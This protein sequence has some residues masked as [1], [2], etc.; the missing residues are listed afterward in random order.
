MNLL[1]IDAGWSKTRASTGLAWWVDG[2][3]SARTS[4]DRWPQDLPAVAWDLVVL[5]APVLP[6]LPPEQVRE[7][8]KALSLG[9]FQKRCKPGFTHVPGTGQKFR[10]V[11]AEF[12]RKIRP[13]MEPRTRGPSR[14]PRPIEG[15]WVLETFPNAFL[16]VCLPDSAFQRRPLRRRKKFDWLFEQACDEKVLS[17]LLAE[18]GLPQNSVAETE[19]EGKHDKRAALVCLVAAALVAKERFTAVGEDQGGYVFLPPEGHFQPWAREAA[20]RAAERTS[21]CILCEGQR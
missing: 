4:N 18:A 5:D 7:W 20:K 21:V 12:V 2:R 9:L 16:G 6:S 17:S 13:L 1:G 15:L 10:C 19:G 14:A 3:L 11:G 8:E